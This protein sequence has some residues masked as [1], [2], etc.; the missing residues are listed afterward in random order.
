MPSL[1]QTF[2]CVAAI[3]FAAGLCAGADL[4]SAQRAYEKKDYVTALKEATP[5][6]EQGNADAQLLV[7]RMYLMGQGVTKDN[8]R[9]GK[10]FE[11]SAAQGNADAQFMLGS[12]YLLPQKDV[13]KGANWLRLSADQ[14]NQDAQYLLGKALIQG[15]PGLPRDPVQAE[16]WL[17]LAARKNLQF[18]KSELD[19]AE[20]KMTPNEIASGRALAAAWKPKGT[21][22]P[23]ADEEF[24]KDGRPKFQ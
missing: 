8:D 3:V 2:L 22:Q 12:M 11:A 6:A 7:G 13:P 21:Q 23:K 9:A 19:N 1:R 5:V 16:L 18:Y 14:G 17:S 4:A 24:R 10:W 20:S 15:L